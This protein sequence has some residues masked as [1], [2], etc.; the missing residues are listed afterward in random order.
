MIIIYDYESWLKYNNTF[1]L[2]M[3]LNISLNSH[4]F[5]CGS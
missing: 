1:E 4:I 3:K 2:T 5:G